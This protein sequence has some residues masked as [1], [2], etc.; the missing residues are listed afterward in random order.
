M[1]VR[2]QGGCLPGLDPALRLAPLC[3]PTVTVNQF[4]MTPTA[5]SYTV[6]HNISYYIQ[7]VSLVWQVRTSS[8]PSFTQLRGA[9]P[10]VEC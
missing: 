9:A 1:R 6:V 7:I 2:A 3:C 5:I 8:R 10:A 4:G